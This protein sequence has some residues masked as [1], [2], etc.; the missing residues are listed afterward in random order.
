VDR[1]NIFPK[2]SLILYEQVTT[3]L[4]KKHKME[5]SAMKYKGSKPRWRT[6]TFYLLGV[7]LVLGVLVLITG[8]IIKIPIPYLGTFEV[9]HD[10]AKDND[11]SQI[12]RIK[13][14]PRDLQGTP[15]VVIPKIWAL[16]EER[17]RLLEEKKGLENDIQNSFRIIDRELTTNG[18]INTNRTVIDERGREL[19]KHI[20]RCLMAIGHYNSDINGESGLTSSAV[21]QFQASKSITVDGV[22]G[23]N[24]W[25][26]ILEEFELKKLQ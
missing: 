24:T 11:M 12:L 22:I 4:L 9:V 3:V 20:Q 26:K 5:C 2:R 16:L 10:K 17:N 21:K 8:G 14:L 19:N 13:D 1:K 15:D 25:R 23:R 7:V 6:L 18:T